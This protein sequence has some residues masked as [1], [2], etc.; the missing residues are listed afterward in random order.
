MAVAQE[1][2]E[3]ID[4]PRRLSPIPP[5]RR[6]RNSGPIRGFNDE[7]AKEFRP[8][9]LPIEPPDNKVDQGGGSGNTSEAA[10]T[11][12]FR[13]GTVAAQNRQRQQAQTGG[14]PMSAIAAAGR[15]K[16]LTAGAEAVVS[17]LGAQGFALVTII[18]FLRK[19]KT[20]AFIVL[21]II[22]ATAFFLIGFLI[23]IIYYAVN[24]CEALKLPLPL[25][26]KVI[27]TLTNI[28]CAFK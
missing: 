8:L 5:V 10:T 9:S 2:S 22:G 3:Q 27:L 19:H 24:P 4:T 14:S 21:F 26:I 25:F 18:N 23:I 1:A 13:A 12:E 15:E 16:A 6:L 20:L 11:Q 7:A 17:K 28:Q